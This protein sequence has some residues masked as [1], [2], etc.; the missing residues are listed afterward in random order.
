MR[1]PEVV[2]RITVAVEGYLDEA[3]A[4]KLIAHV[5]GATGEVYGRTGKPYLF[6]QIDCFNNAARSI[7]GPWLVLIDLD[8]DADCA[9]A[10]RD[11]WL[12]HPA[13]NLCF[14]IAVRE[15]EAWLMADAKALSVYLSVSANRISENPENLEKPKD[16]MVNLARRS[17]RPAIK[18]DMAPRE[19]S[20]RRVGAAY[21]SRLIEYVRN[22]WRP[23]VAVN[24]SE[25][26]FR[27]I[28]CLEKL[29]KAARNKPRNGGA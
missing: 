13:P 5:G 9:P 18:R 21:A 17:R 1:E 11:K 28:C 16:D 23:E 15:V 19:G 26:L 22:K 10:L 14:R 6:K 29:I 4:Q 25:S 12:P 24:R 2:P 7:H 3:V 8:R 20:G 27:A